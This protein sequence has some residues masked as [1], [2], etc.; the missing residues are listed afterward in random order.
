[1]QRPMLT[2]A[3]NRAL[4]PPCHPELAFSARRVKAK[5]AMTSMLLQA[6]T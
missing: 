2:R 4:P 6:L 1:M 3:G 5:S